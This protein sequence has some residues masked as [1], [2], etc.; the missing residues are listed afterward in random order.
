MP[1]VPTPHLRRTLVSGCV[2]LLSLA[3][4]PMALAATHIVVLQ[5][6]V[7]PSK[8]AAKYDLAPEHIYSTVLSGYAADVPDTVVT[9]LQ[10]D[11]QVESVQVDS[12]SAR[13]P[14]PA[15]SDAEQP[16]Q[17]VSNAVRRVGGLQS[18]T[19]RIDGVD[20][21]VDLDVAVLDGG[22]Q[23]DHPDL[24]VVGGQDCAP[25]TG[26]YDRDGHGTMVAGFIGAIDNSIG[27]VGVAPGVRIHAVRVARQDGFVADSWLLCGLDWV[28]RNNRTI[29]VANLSLSGPAKRFAPCGSHKPKPSAVQEAV[30]EVVKRGVTV[31]VAAG[32]EAQDTAGIEPALMPEVITVSAISDRD[33]LPGGLAGNLSCLPNEVDD[34]FATYS[35]FGASV[36]IAAPGSCVGS[37]YIGS[38]YA[39]SSGTSFATPLVAGG[40]ALYLANNRTAS[41]SR[42]SRELVELSTPGPIPGDPDSYPEGVLDVSTL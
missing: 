22:V 32:N 16:P 41:P 34:T 3:T 8:H 21:R 9:Q 26:W 31:V 29:K 17:S 40:A 7:K 25:G 14:E 36:D 10:A 39:V 30:C 20:E 37:T 4:A 13:S 27:R 28:G 24:N 42:V 19:A 2:L 11:P 5:P 1:S 12:V 18:P 15:V 6:G 23:P 38:R 33:G 35:N